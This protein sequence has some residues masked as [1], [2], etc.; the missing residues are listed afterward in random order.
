MVLKERTPHP[1]CWSPS[2]YWK[3]AEPKTLVLKMHQIKIFLYCYTPTMCRFQ[4][5]CNYTESQWSYEDTFIW[6]VHV[7][8]RE[9]DHMSYDPHQ[10]R[11]TLKTISCIFFVRGGLS[12]LLIWTEQLEVCV[13]VWCEIG[14]TAECMCL[15]M[16]VPNLLLL[17]W[18]QEPYCIETDRYTALSSSLTV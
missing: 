16:P 15:C 1:L 4:S 5:P 18:R 3:W 10:K 17:T 7:T 9:F 6:G 12:S 11:T 8:K 2:L 14:R 13:C